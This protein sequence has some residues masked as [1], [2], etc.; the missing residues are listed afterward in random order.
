MQGYV[1]VAEWDP[2]ENENDAHLGCDLRKAVSRRLA[3]SG[4]WESRA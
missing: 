2:A 1:C 4:C 3:G